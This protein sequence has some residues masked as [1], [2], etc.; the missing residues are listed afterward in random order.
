MAALLLAAAVGECKV[1][2]MIRLEDVYKIY[3]MGDNE[4]RAI[5]GMTLEIR[6]NEMA[7][8]IGQSGSGNPPA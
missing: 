5:D 2:A 1:N 3:Q 8:I 7:A 6:E 4:V